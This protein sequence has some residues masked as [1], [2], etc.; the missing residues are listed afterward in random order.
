MP[1]IYGN[2]DANGTTEFVDTDFSIKKSDGTT[3]KFDLSGQNTGTTATLYGFH[4]GAF[5]T[6]S[7]KPIVQNQEDLDFV[8]FVSGVAGT[9]QVTANHNPTSYTLVNPPAEVSIDNTGLITY[10]GIVT[11]YV[12]T[13]QVY[14]SN[15][16]GAGEQV[17]IN[18]NIGSG[19]QGNP[20]LILSAFDLTEPNGTALGT[21]S[22]TGSGGGQ[23]T[24][25]TESEKPTVTDSVFTSGT[26][27]VKFDGTDDSIQSDGGAGVRTT[28]IFG[29]GNAA[30]EIYVAFKIDTV[31]TA[32]EVLFTMYEAGQLEANKWIQFLINGGYSTLQGGR[33]IDNTL[34]SNTITILNGPQGSNVYKY[35]INQ[36]INANDVFVMRLYWG[37]NKFNVQIGKNSTPLVF[38]NFAPLSTAG[39]GSQPNIGKDATTGNYYSGYVGALVAFDTR[40]TEEQAEANFAYLESLYN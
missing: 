26:K 4:N 24:Q 40:L 29:A 6:K 8:F 12:G 5:V 11:S 23:Y 30:G 9:V 3:I 22:N 32:P 25:T 14:A 16:F 10:D 21:W 27:G 2:I 20:S 37:A 35:T 19:F 28:D 1:K 38:S 33:R 18:L 13:I 15:I 36:T 39:F 7:E 34:V 31:P 17:D